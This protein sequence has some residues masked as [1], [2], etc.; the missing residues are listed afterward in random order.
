MRDLL[1]GYHAIPAVKDLCALCVLCR[2]SSY[3]HR[4]QNAQRSGTVVG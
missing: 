2:K 4:R 3:L 1:Y